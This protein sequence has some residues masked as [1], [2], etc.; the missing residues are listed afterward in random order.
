VVLPLVVTSL[1][2]RK[3]T[4]VKPREAPSRPLWRGFSM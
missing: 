1:N 2:P 3:H 4:S